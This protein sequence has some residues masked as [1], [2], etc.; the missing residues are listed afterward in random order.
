MEKQY[1]YWKGNVTWLCKQCNGSLLYTEYI[2][3]SSL[4]K[5]IA[6][7]ICFGDPEISQSHILAIKAD[8][9]VWLTPQTVN[10]LALILY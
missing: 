1:K 6:D 2:F 8:G 5:I 4:S 9:D 10:T 3:V 7:Y